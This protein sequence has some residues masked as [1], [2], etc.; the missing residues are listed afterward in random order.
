MVEPRCLH[1]AIRDS[2]ADHSVL[3]IGV[4]G[5]GVFLHNTNLHTACNVTTFANLRPE[6]R[7]DNALVHVQKSHMDLK[8][9]LNV[10]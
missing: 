9:M 5:I 8:L 3:V 1:Q 10:L 4:H 7:P 2:S 6:G